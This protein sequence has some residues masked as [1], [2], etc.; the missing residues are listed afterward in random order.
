[1]LSLLTCKKGSKFSFT[2]AFPFKKS[3]PTTTTTITTSTRT[4]PTLEIAPIT[5]CIVNGNDNDEDS[6]LKQLIHQISPKSLVQHVKSLDDDT[7]IQA[8]V[9]VVVVNKNDNIN[10]ECL[11]SNAIV[12]VDLSS[13]VKINHCCITRPYR[14]HAVREKVFKTAS[15][16]KCLINNTD[17]VANQALCVKSFSILVVD[18]NIINKKVMNLMLQKLKI[19][20]DLV[21]NGLEAV[22]KVKDKHYDIIFMDLMVCF[23]LNGRLTSKRCL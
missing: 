14:I 4:L 21:S 9:I 2:I 19:N 17:L 16:E 3:V 23:V 10:Q 1:M 13:H 11:P 20:A 12:S 5:V 22:Q 7:V 8:H 15:T 18:D 6:S